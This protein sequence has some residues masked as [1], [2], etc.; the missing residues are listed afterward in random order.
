MKHNRSTIA[1]RA[2]ALA[3]TLGQSLAWRKA[4]AE[5]K[6]ASIDRAFDEAM[7]EV[8]AVWMPIREARFAA[9]DTLAVINQEAEAANPVESM[10]SRLFV[11]KMADRPSYQERE[12]ITRLEK[13]LAA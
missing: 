1:R 3:R 12:E 7:H 6:L 4:W 10:K 11:L 2:N 9:M 13:L 8:P 5:E